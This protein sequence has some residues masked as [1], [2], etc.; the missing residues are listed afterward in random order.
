MGCFQGIS[1]DAGSS[2]GMSSTGTSSAVDSEST[3]S[4]SVALMNPV[5]SQM[6]AWYQS[7]PSASLTGPSMMNTSLPSG[8][9]PIAA[10]EYDASARSVASPP[11]VE[12]M[13]VS[14]ETRSPLPRATIGANRE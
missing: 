14:P 8:I 1:V 7:D 6:P 4:R 9:Y 13:A 2:A 11:P 3:P 5:L 12:M 10:A